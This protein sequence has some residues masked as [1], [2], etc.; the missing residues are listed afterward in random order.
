MN[1]YEG[2]D[3]F[4]TKV[5]AKEAAKLPGRFGIG[6]DDL[7]D[8][9]QD[10]HQQV[11]RKMA[12]TFSQS[13]PDYKAAV[14]RTVDSKIKDIIDHRSAGKRAAEA[15]SIDAPLDDGGPEEE[16]ATFGDS[17]DLELL[18]E[19]LSGRA[20]AWHRRRE[21]KIDVEEAVARLPDDLRRLADTLAAL[22]GNHS[23]AERELGVTRKKFRCDIEKLRRLMADFLEM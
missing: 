21:A 20:A 17:I 8:I 22:G 9:H 23:A 16:S 1:R 15:V 14:R 5:I 11:W 10:L 18:A 6:A 13:D 2:I 12:G 7:D 4:I 19:D 3:E